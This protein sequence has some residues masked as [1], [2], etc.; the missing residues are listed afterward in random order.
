MLNNSVMQDSAAQKVVEKI[1]LVQLY[2]YRYYCVHWRPTSKTNRM[3]LVTDRI[4]EGGN[5]IA[6]VRLSICPS[7]RLL[8]HCLRNRLTVDLELM[9]VS[10]GCR[11]LKVKV[12]GQRHGSG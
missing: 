5:V 3:T 11:E 8:P 1:I 6:S 4:S 10:I 9:R 7:V 12:I 2:Q